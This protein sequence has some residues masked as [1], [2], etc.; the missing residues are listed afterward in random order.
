M[1]ADPKPGGLA[2][3]RGWFIVSRWQEY[4][5]EARA[6]LLRTIGIG[7]FY[8]IEL[9]NHGVHVGALQLPQVSNDRFHA[10]VSGLAVI[11]T[12]VALVTLV[13]LRRQFF[14]P[15]AKYVTTTCDLV[16]L[17]AV[18]AIAD[19]PRSPLIVIYFLI[20]ALA[21]LRL[22]PRLIAMATLGSLAGYLFLLGYVKYCASEERAAAMSV[23]RYYQLIVL[24]AF[25]LAGVILGQVI[26][27][28]RTMAEDFS[29]RV[30]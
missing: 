26:R 8:I 6:N 5:G 30:D 13:C 11:W 17:T 15:A 9:I 4:Q 2:R 25:A 19:G 20:I 27:Q 10:L 28:V 12:M 7:A 1:T 3:D 23:P 21:A 14:P 22:S 18:L 29:R 16:L 24:V